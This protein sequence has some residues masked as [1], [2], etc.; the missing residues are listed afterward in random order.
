MGRILDKKK[1]KKKR[2]RIEQANTRR[3][4]HSLLNNIL[5]K[6]NQAETTILK[7]EGSNGPSSLLFLFLKSYRQIYKN[8]SLYTLIFFRRLYRQGNQGSVLGSITRLFIPNSK[9]RQIRLI[10]VCTS[11]ITVLY[12]LFPRIQFILLQQNLICGK[13]SVT[14]TIL[15][16]MLVRKSY[17]YR[18]LQINE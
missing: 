1:K 5:P 8:L 17:S 2:R 11:L 4:K 16:D 6:L 15:L 13:P 18:A 3:K 14:Y 12:P 7:I 10:G 9:I